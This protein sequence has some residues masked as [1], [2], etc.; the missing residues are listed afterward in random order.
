MVLL[1][2]C[3]HIVVNKNIDYHYIMKRTIVDCW[4][5][6]CS[7]ASP[8]V[9]NFLWQISWKKNCKVFPF[10]STAELGCQ[11]SEIGCQYS[12]IGAGH[13]EGK[14]LFNWATDKGDPSFSPLPVASIGQHTLQISA[15]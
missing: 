8:G 13:H 14:F 10:I 4:R 9:H 3:D 11:F 1:L 12:E 7:S 2:H 15:S 6:Q 5:D